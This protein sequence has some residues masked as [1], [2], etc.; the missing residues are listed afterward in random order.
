MRPLR[1]R[2]RK[3]SL[4]GKI[5][6]VIFLPVLIALFVLNELVDFTVFM[7][8][9]LFEYFRNAVWDARSYMSDCRNA[10]INEYPYRI[11]AHRDRR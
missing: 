5:K 1:R 8:S 2:F 3:L 9:A 11:E 10:L 4:F 6:L 7:A